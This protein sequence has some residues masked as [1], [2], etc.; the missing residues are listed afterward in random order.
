[1]EPKPSGNIFQAVHQKIAE[2]K[3]KMRRARQHSASVQQHKANLE[4]KVEGFDRSAASPAVP[5]HE[6]TQ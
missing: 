2:Q 4:A 1:M 5:D 6:I 3:D